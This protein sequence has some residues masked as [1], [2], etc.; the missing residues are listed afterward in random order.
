MK[1]K[2]EA[3]DDDSDWTDVEE[4]FPHVQLTELLE[5]LK[6]NDDKPMD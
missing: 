4:D 3:D 1:K 2:N 6:L 5:N